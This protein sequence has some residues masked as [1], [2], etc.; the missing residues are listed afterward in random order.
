MSK[1]LLI[2]SAT[3]RNNLVLAKKIDKACSDIK[4]EVI[5]LEEY[6][7][8]LYTPI[9]EKKCIP[10]QIGESITEKFIDASGFIICAPEYNGSIPPILTSLIAW[11]SVSA[12]DWRAVFSGKVAMIATHSGGGG[13]NLIQSLRCQ[14]NHLGAIVIPRTIIVNSHKA[15]C[16]TTS[17]EKVQQLIDL[18]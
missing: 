14:L 12:K 5:N 4:R 9:E 15:Y 16:K 11:I 3:S 8:P 7:I 1:K 17:Q 18:L 6:D 10:E 13:N 2:I